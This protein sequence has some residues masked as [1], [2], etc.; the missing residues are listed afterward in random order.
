[1]SKALAVSQFRVVAIGILY[2]DRF[3]LFMPFYFDGE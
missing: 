2:L 3:S 1:M